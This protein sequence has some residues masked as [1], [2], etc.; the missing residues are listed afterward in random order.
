MRVSHGLGLTLPGPF[1]GQV[2]E[3]D[4]VLSAILVP[5]AVASVC[6]VPKPR[7]AKV[8]LCRDGS[9]QSAGSAHALGI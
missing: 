9:L 1:S 3:R 4:S 8:N 6:T 5:P 2:Q 7:N